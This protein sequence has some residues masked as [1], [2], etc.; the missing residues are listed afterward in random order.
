MRLWEVMVL[1]SLAMGTVAC[2][3]GGTK[4]AAADDDGGEK[5]KK[6]KKRKKSDDEP[7]KAKKPEKK[8]PIEVTWKRGA[9]SA[10]TGEG[11]GRLSIYKGKLQLSLTKWPK[12]TYYEIGDEKGTIDAYSAIVV[13]RDAMDLYAKWPV[14]DL[15]NHTVDL[16]ATVSIIRPD[17]THADVKLEPYKLNVFSF[18]SDIEAV[19]N[20]PY[21][22]PGEK[23]DDDPKPGRS[24]FYA[25]G[26]GSRRVFGQAT[27]MSDIDAV[28]FSRMLPEVKG[29][30]TC[31]GYTKTSNRKEKMP[32]IE[33]QLKETEVVI[34][35]RR[36]G[37]EITKKVFPPEKRCP[38]FVST[39]AGDNTA[40]STIPFR[41]IEAWL[42]TQAR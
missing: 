42:R 12:G 31:G 13:L 40:D 10:A 16:E 15:M 11:E 24:I 32:D 8:E 1:A 7:K 2:D 35:D 14:K 26:V 25:N 3:L 18:K 17:G 34:Y 36:K 28:A 29:T 21:L 39:S 22:F 27:V 30:K 4:D 20:G 9:F 37:G 5:K 19:Q 23:A 38:S 33:V 6:K 41:Q